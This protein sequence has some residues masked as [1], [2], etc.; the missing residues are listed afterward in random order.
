MNQQTNMGHFIL[1]AYCFVQRK[2]RKNGYGWDWCIFFTGEY[3]V[4]ILRQEDM[5]HENG[6]VGGVGGRRLVVVPNCVG[7]LLSSHPS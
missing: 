7:S 1:A 2:V 3:T 4:K 6:L 5:F